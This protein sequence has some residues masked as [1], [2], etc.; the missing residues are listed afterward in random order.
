[1]EFVINLF[2][3]INMNNKIDQNAKLNKINNK[4]FLK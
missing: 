4:Q 3:R 1:M 2:D